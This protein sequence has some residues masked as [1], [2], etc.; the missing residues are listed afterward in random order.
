MT[1]WVNARHVPVEQ[2]RFD[3][4]ENTSYIIEAMRLLAPE[5]NVI[6]LCQAGVPALV[7]TAYHADNEQGCAPDSL[8]LIAA[9]IDPAANPTRVSRLIR[10][11]T[12]SWY[13]RN[14]VT[15]ITSSDAGKGRLVYP[16]SVQLLGLWAYLARH[17][18]EG[19]ELLGK[20][21][22]DDG[23]DP[24]RFPFLDLYSAVMDLPAE[25]FLDIMS[26][27]Y[28]ERTLVRGKFRARNQT[29]ALR[30]IRATALMTVEGEYD[31]IAA[32]GQTQRAHDLCPSVPADARQRLVVSGC[33]HFSLFH[34]EIWRTRVLPEMLSFMVQ[35]GRTGKDA[36]R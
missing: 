15:E 14:V 36:K 9:P 7:A 27:V 35:S 31:D 12:L 23:A 24:V 30:S 5:L 28:Q 29:V 20:V 13:E 11:R 3:L 32:P 8:V 33:G 25:V 34:G 1:D 10:A 26:H 17:L 2:G 19:G 6:A 4:D 18:R 21:L 22:T 16:G